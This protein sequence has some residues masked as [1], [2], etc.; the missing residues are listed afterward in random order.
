MEKNSIIESLSPNERK[1]LP[2]LKEKSVN[3]I[4]KKTGLDDTSILRSL[5]FLENKG[6]IKVKLE[7]TKIVDLGNNGV[8]YLKNGLPERRLLTALVEKKAI[9]LND[10]SLKLSDNEFKASIGALKKKAMIELKDNKIILN[11]NMSEISRK[12]LEE[13]F[14]ES[15][16]IELE[17]LAPEQLYSLKT[18]ES[19]KDIIKI[20]EQQKVIFELTDLGKELMSTDLSHADNLIE[21]LTPEM[22]RDEAWK[23]K[24]FRRYDVK[25]RIP[26]ISGGKKHFVSQGIEYAKRIW[27]D[28]GFE[29]M[30]S[31][32][33]QTGFWNFDALFTAQDHPVREIQDTFYLKGIT[34]NL[35][36]QNIVRAIKQAHELG[37]G[38]SKG[39]KYK[40]NGE[41]PKRVILRTHTTCL[42]AR[43]LASLRNAKN[44]R[45]KFFSVGKCF[46][47]ETIDWSH[48]FEFNQTEGI[49][50]DPDANFRHLLG[51]LKEFFSKMGFD[52]VKL[53]PSYFPYTEPS[54]EIYGY[55]KDKKAWTEIGGAGIF[56]P[57][58]VIPLLGEYIPVLAWGPGF[59][60]TL[61]DYYGISDLRDFYNNNLEML[62]KIKFWCK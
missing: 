31:T 40:W 61:M 54:V 50:I 44:K 41:D 23:G 33:C 27:M 52:D 12:T 32:L 45:G 20:E 10:K 2:H 39:W 6:L 58:V 55:L 17:K 15:L 57:E 43:T 16:P 21:A 8:L 59:D 9:P 37:C 13:Q 7:K 36:D 42:S 30:Q 34:G 1:I 11:A 35:P 62:R 29:E 3:S 53:V 18:L 26:K 22:L 24:K 60:R 14:L 46:R 51:Y 25:S 5:R 56:R 28:M 4:S 49:V 38:G 19:R 47:N 48:G